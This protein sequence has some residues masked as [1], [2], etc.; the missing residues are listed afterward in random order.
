MR[1]FLA[2]VAVVAI[3]L[4]ACEKGNDEPTYT[5][6]LDF[7]K[8]EITFAKGGGEQTLGFAIINPMGGKVTIEEN[9]EWMDARVEFNSDIIINVEANEGD[10]REATILVKYKGAKD[11]KLVVRQKAGNAGDYDVEFEAKRFEGI[12]GGK[13]G[14]TYNYYVILS[15][16]GVSKSGEAKA[17]GTYYY[18]DLYSSTAGDEEYPVLPNGTYTFDANNTYASG[19]FSDE[20]SWYAVMDAAGGFA[21]ARS[22]KSA[23]VTVED[24]RFEAVIEY[25]SGETHHVVYE[26]DLYVGIDDIYSTF[27][28]DFT[29]DI[30]G[31]TI[32]ATN[33]GDVLQNGMQNWFIEAV[34]GDEVFML[35]L[36]TSSTTSPAANYTKLAN[37]TSD[38]NNKFIPGMMDNGL[39]GAWYAKV[40]DGKI[41]GD[42]WAPI[43][44]GLIQVTVEGGSATITYSAKDDAGNKI[45]GT[46]SG[47]YTKGV[48][49][50]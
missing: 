23:T 20:S 16:I 14:N 29:F 13:T 24:E 10:A 11:V 42:V 35:D 22:Y 3:A 15:D 27:T 2:L 36:F 32:T 18:F 17:K 26:G 44:D 33:Y 39:I 31:A 21:T 38:Y 4:T 45:E 6:S 43:V 5:S 34:K 8:K 19:T 7:S 41:K 40:T 48:P 50:E 30:K 25:S 47:S 9:A 12:Y 37:D 28:E 49:E 1:K 46:I